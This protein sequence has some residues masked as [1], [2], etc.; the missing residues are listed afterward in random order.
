QRGVDG[1]KKKGD[2]KIMSAKDT[3]FKMA[4]TSI[5]LLELCTRGQAK[6]VIPK[7]DYNEI[8]GL[9]QEIRELAETLP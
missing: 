9:V 5:R 4:M 2:S 1:A 7:K 8:K 6:K 3:L